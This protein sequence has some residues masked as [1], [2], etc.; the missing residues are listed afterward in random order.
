MNQQI[1]FWSLLMMLI[2]WVLG[3]G[4]INTIQKNIDAVLVTNKEIC[5]EVNEE[6]TKYMCMAYE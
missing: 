1:N 3:G 2:Y 4:D 5:L 6:N